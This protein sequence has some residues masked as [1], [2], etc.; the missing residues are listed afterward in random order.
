MKNS[1]LQKRIKELEELL[2]EEKIKNKNLEENNT[3][4][5]QKLKEKELNNLAQNKE[6]KNLL[7]KEKVESLEFNN[8]I[9]NVN[10]QST[11]NNYLGQKNLNDC[12]SNEEKPKNI[13]LEHNLKKSE[14]EKLMSI[15]ISTLDEKVTYQ[16]ICK[17][18][19]KF[20]VIKQKFYS[21]HP[22]F[23]GKYNV[24]KVKGKVINSDK[25]LDEN[26]IKSNDII[27]L[28]SSQ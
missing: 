24:F 10:N 6:I 22:E 4:L 11:N 8:N 21:K 23:S 2:K 27:I 16:L 7:F 28:N 14:G 12:I 17:N 25:S 3:K 5:I 18:T 9:N 15:V 13:S 20:G 26:N 1:D 19:D